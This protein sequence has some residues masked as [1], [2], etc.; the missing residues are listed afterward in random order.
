MRQTKLSTRLRTSTSQRTFRRSPSIALWLLGVALSTINVYGQNALPPSSREL[1]TTDA[2]AF[3]R[4]L[5]TNRPTP[6]SAD[7]KAAILSSLPR[8]GEVKPLGASSQRKLAGLNAFL[9]QTGHDGAFE[10]KVTDV[11]DARIGLYER[12]V[13]LISEPAFTLLGL[14]ELQAL[15][16]H[17]IGHQYLSADRAREPALKAQ[18]GLRD[19]ELLCDA[20]AIVLLRELEIDSSRLVAGIEKITK[21]NW[22]FD[23]DVERRTYPSLSERRKF[24]REV[25][26]WLT[27]ASRPRSSR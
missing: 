15:L 17:E 16:A 1:L 3:A 11:A 20:I 8:E 24:A 6:V 22:L 27:R 7:Q 14:E 2:G 19:L 26:A 18:R 21:Y 4:W 12:T 10:I 23:L 9:R 13:V 5:E 25:T